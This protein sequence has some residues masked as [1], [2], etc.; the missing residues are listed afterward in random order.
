MK[1]FKVSYIIAMLLPMVDTLAQRRPTTKKQCNNDQLI[2]QGAFLVVKISITMTRRKT[3]RRK[4]MFLRRVSYLVVNSPK[5]GCK[6]TQILAK[7]EAGQFRGTFWSSQTETMSFASVFLNKKQLL[8]SCLPSPTYAQH[9]L[10]LPRSVAGPFTTTSC[11]AGRP[12]T[13]LLH[14]RPPLSS[15][16]PPILWFGCF[17]R[18]GPK[19]LLLV[20]LIFGFKNGRRCISLM[21]E[22]LICCLIEVLMLN[23]KLELCLEFVEL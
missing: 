19:P 17:K 3:G 12:P 1:K 7:K 21:W 18:W 20:L 16:P 5:P 13:P 8:L 14:R 23:L 4:Y 15:S 6:Y 9:P 11:A 10:L 22:L 2:Q